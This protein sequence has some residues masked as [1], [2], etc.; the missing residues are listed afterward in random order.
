MSCRPIRFGI[1]RVRKR[2][3]LARVG[4]AEQIQSAYAATGGTRL[5]RTNY[6][7]QGKAFVFPSDEAP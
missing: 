1:R 2:N 3:A 7:M 6:A 4:H 5:V